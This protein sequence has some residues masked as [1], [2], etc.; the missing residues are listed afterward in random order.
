MEY[1]CIETTSGGAGDLSD[2]TYS[3]SLSEVAFDTQTSALSIL[4]S[5]VASSVLAPAIYSFSITI[6]AGTLLD[7]SFTK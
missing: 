7:V 1:G 2:C 4:S 3:D 5:D 6:L